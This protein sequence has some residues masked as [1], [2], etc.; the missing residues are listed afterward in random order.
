ME[1]SL[2]NFKGNLMSDV[3]SLSF[4]VNSSID[5]ALKE[6]RIVGTVVMIAKGEDILYRRAAGKLDREN[7]IDMRQDAIF[8]LSSVTKPLVSVAAMRFVERGLLDLEQ[9]V[10]HW[11]KDFRP[12]LQDNSEPVITLHHLLAHMAGLSYGFLEPEDSAYHKLQVSDGLDQPGLELSENLRRLAKA[13]LAFEPGSAWRYSLATDVI[14]A[15]L[16][17]VTGKSLEYIIRQEITEPLNLSDTSFRVSDH[18]RLAV[19]YAN[20]QDKVPLRMMG[21]TSLEL[22]GGR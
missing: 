11:L 8:R 4:L 21:D 22:W 15:V 20:V 1:W 9:P 6:Q 14:G 5:N 17:A 2:L 3:Q 7:A 19:P 18:S 13:P 16:E 12:K 10:T